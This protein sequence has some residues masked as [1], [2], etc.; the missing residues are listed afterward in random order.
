MYREGCASNIPNSCRTFFPRTC[1]CL[2]DSFSTEVRHGWLPV[3]L[4]ASSTLLASLRSDG[5]LSVATEFQTNFIPARVF[6]R[7]AIRAFGDRLSVG[8]ISAVRRSGE[9]WVTHVLREVDSYPEVGFLL[10]RQSREFTTPAGVFYSPDSP[11]QPQTHFLRES[12]LESCS[13]LLVCVVIVRRSLVC[14][15]LQTSYN[16]RCRQPR[17]TVST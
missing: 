6:E 17:N 8:G 7:P 9:R 10:V 2:V 11:R 3:P 5:A 12:R 13:F 1:C 4:D 15:A 14:S 16:T